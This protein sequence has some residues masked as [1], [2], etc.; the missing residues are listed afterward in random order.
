[1]RIVLFTNKQTGEV[2]CFTSLKP[3]FDKYPLFKENE[4][5]INTYLSRKKQ[6]FETEEIKVQRLEVQRSL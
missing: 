2:E 5:N 3:F 6:A 4:D 1:M